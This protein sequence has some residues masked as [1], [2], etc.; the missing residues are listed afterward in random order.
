MKST[1]RSISL[2]ATSLL[3]ACGEGAPQQEGAGLPTLEDSHAALVAP[4]ASISCSSTSTDITCIGGATGGS[5]LYRSQWSRTMYFDGEVLNSPWGDGSAT[6]S[7]SCVTPTSG[8]PPG[9]SIRFRYR[10]VTAAQEVS[11][12]ATGPLYACE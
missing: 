4:T 9:Y 11:N 12:V 8:N 3:M 6:Y 2:M 10:V 1:L 7:E 5:P